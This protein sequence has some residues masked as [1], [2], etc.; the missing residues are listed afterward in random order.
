M[1]GPPGRGNADRFDLTFGPLLPMNTPSWAPA[2]TVCLWSSPVIQVRCGRMSGLP[3]LGAR[4]ARALVNRL[5]VRGASPTLGFQAFIRVPL[6]NDQ[7]KSRVGN[8]VPARAR[9]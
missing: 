4:G 8:G 5:A 9:P 3:A 7:T 2:R 1:D 6:P